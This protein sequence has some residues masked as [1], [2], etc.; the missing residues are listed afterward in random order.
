MVLSSEAPAEVCLHVQG[1]DELI[2]TLERKAKAS[3]TFAAI[4]CCITLVLLVLDI[5]IP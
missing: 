3:K 5:L 1:N 4:V 2:K